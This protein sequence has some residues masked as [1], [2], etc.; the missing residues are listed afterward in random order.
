M[1]IFFVLMLILTNMA[2]TQSQVSQSEIKTGVEDL[3]F[4]TNILYINPAHLFKG[5]LTLSFEKFIDS[6]KS[7][8]F[9]ISGSEKAKY[10]LVAVDAN[11]YTSRRSKINYFLGLSAFGYESPIV[12]GVPVYYPFNKFSESVDD[13]YYLGLQVKNGAIFKISKFAF[14]EI[15]AAIGPVYN[16][17]ESKWLAVWAINLNLGIPF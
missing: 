11:Y 8:K 10:I 15:D 4:K 2:Y 7:L 16:I 1:K 17:D 3:D 9:I 6:R 5:N 14:F 12:T 13:I